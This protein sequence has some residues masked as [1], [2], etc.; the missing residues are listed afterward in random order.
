MPCTTLRTR[1]RIDDLCQ[2]LFSFHGKCEKL[3]VILVVY[4]LQ[5]DSEKSG[6][7]VNGTSLFGSF[8][9]GKYPRAMELLKKVDLFFSLTEC[10]VEPLFFLIVNSL[11]LP[12]LLL[13][14]SEAFLSFL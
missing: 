12:P 4:Y 3:L 5:K 1:R 6:C 9:S 2:K 10:S 14:Y 11:T 13:L 7:K 8:Y